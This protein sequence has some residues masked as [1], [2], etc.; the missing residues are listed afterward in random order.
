MKKTAVRCRLMRATTH[1]LDE[2]TVPF[3]LAAEARLRIM[4]DP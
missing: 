3:T 2:L 1:S 4:A